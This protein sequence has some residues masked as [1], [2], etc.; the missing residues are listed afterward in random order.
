MEVGDRVVSVSS[1]G[2]G[3][4]IEYNIEGFGNKRFFVEES[5]A[6]IESL[7]DSL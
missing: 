5:P 7:I 6:T 2:T 1:D 4:S 3:S